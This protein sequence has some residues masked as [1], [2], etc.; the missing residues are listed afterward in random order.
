[1]KSP[2]Q[3]L[4]EPVPGAVTAPSHQAR[5]PFGC[6]FLGPDPTLSAAAQQDFGLSLDKWLWLEG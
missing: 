2:I 1:M 3:V 6:D 5:A 4:K